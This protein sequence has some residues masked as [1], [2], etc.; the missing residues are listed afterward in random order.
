MGQLT[1]EDLMCLSAE[2]R[3]AS[4]HG[5]GEEF[6]P[7]S[8]QSARES[9]D[10]GRTKVLTLYTASWSGESNMHSLNIRWRRY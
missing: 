7:G 1:V 8:A 5:D 9:K 6:E 3:V 4:V 2:G 10:L